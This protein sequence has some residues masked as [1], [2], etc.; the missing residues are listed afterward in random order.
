MRE[1]YT[2][3]VEALLT[4]LVRAWKALQLYPPG[5]PRIRETLGPV[6]LAAQDLFTAIE[7]SGDFSH[8]RESDHSDDEGEGTLFFL[9]VSRNAFLF[10]EEPVGTRFEA[11]GNLAHELYSHGVKVFWVRTGIN[12]PELAQFLGAVCKPASEAALADG[13]QEVDCEHIGI[14]I[15]DTFRV[16]DRTDTHAQ[17]DMLE[18]LRRRQAQRRTPR[19]DEEAVAD[20]LADESEDISDLAEFFLEISQ[21]SAEKNRYLFNNLTNPTRLAETLSYLAGMQGAAPDDAPTLATDVLRQTLRHIADSINTLPDDL[22]QKIVQN[23][24]EAVLTTDDRTRERIMNDAVASQLGMDP[25]SNE[26][27]AAMPDAEIANLLS[28]HIRLHSGTA[29]TISNFLDD[30]AADEARR[31]SIRHL[32]ADQLSVYGEDYADIVQLLLESDEMR[33]DR[34]RKKKAPLDRTER[35][36]LD[37]DRAA[38]ARELALTD[39]ESEELTAAIESVGDGTELEHA[40]L[41]VLALDGAPPSEQIIAMTRRALELALRRGHFQFVSRT[42]NGYYDNRKAAVQDALRDMLGEYL[43]RLADPECLARI[44]KSM[45]PLRRDDPEFRRMASMLRLGGEAVYQVAF[46]QLAKERER[47]RRLFLLA[48]FVEIGDDAVYFLSRQ[49]EHRDWFVVRNVAYLLGKIGLDIGVDALER[50][51]HHPDMRVQREVLRSLATIKGTQAEGILK[52]CLRDPEPSIRGLAAEWLGI[53]RAP[54]IIDVYRTMLREEEHTLRTEPEL[55]L[56]IIRSL[57][58]LGE[59]EDVELLQGFHAHIRGVGGSVREMLLKA[60]EEALAEIAARLSP[61]QPTTRS[62]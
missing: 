49:I 22:R 54:G 53:M 10:N 9:R 45:E 13:W 28:A 43:T 62:E 6:I 23:I 41:T 21:G 58:R 16:V 4:A 7:A 24:A 27:C 12:A 19:N 8:T 37:A 15:I 57:A 59:A 2:Q 47:A 60:C 44:L 11:V 46:D 14:E 32:V 56:G 34:R 29:H 38:L 52:R 3:R 61:P 5:N 26:I 1:S 40:A 33:D 31:S 39:A 51:L 35:E 50:V 36:R 18:Y 20:T 42:L 25:L 17:V 48:L 55:T 30:F